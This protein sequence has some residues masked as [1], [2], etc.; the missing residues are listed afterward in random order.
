M[1]TLYDVLRYLLENARHPLDEVKQ[2]A[3]KLVDKLET[4]AGLA[5]ADT[6]PAQESQSVPAATPT[7]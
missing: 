1:N 5:P 6:A 7:A 3:L 2:E 4:D